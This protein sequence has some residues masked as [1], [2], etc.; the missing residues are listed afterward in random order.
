MEQLVEY[1]SPDRGS[2]SNVL[3]FCYFMQDM[4][5]LPCVIRGSLTVP[6]NMF[7]IFILFFVPPLK[8]LFFLLLKLM[9]LSASC[10]LS[11]DSL[12]FP[13]FATCRWIQMRAGKLN[14]YNI[15][16][17]CKAVGGKKPPVTSVFLVCSSLREIHHSFTKCG[18]RPT[19]MMSPNFR[20][21]FTT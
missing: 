5:T 19:L 7:S 14:F 1:T 15:G 10:P 20:K 2:S 11:R 9:K 6:R 13:N 8:S 12:P 21:L 18:S 3:P 17:E 4:A 16:Q